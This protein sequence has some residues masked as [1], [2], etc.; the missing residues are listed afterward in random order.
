MLS[1]ITGMIVVIAAIAVVALGIFGLAIGGFWGVALSLGTL[2]A[3]MW[4][5]TYVQNYV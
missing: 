3:G 1:V 4:A 5:M 2:S